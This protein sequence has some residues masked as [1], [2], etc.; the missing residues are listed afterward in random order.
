[1]QSI[2]MYLLKVPGQ[3]AAHR[4]DR[5]VKR[6]LLSLQVV[7]KLPMDCCRWRT[8]TLNYVGNYSRG[9]RF[10]GWRAGIFG[11]QAHFWKWRP[12]RTQ[13]TRNFPACRCFGL[14]E[15]P[16]LLHYRSET[17]H[18]FRAA[19]VGAERGPLWQGWPPWRAAVC[20]GEAASAAAALLLAVTAVRQH[21]CAGP[22][23]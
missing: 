6:G 4:L 3:P 17:G 11:P 9:R 1:M 13:P 21:L 16:W 22:P 2:K 18:G 23:A 20:S 5:T 8:L 14:P 10:T 19:C 7:S 12:P 15:G